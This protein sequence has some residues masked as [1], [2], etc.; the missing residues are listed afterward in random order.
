[1]SKHHHRR[2]RQAQYR[3]MLRAELEDER[4][5]RRRFLR[6]LNHQGL[7]IAPDGHPI[8]ARLFAAFQAWHA[9]DPQSA[10]AGLSLLERVV[11]Q[12]QVRPHLRR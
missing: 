4:A 6:I 5:I 12:I 9:H 2:T 8:K 1:M 11:R 3:D 10:W 7:D